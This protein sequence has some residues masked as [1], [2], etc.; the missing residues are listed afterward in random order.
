MLLV[1]VV[2]ATAPTGFAQVPPRPDWRR[3]GNSAVDLS[4]AAVTTGPVARVWYRQ[5]G[6]RLFARS[7]NGRIFYTD[8]F[9]SWTAAPDGVA[10]GPPAVEDTPAPTRPETFV[11]VRGPATRIYAAGRYV[12]KSEDGGRNWANLTRYKERSLIGSGVA[13]LAV[14]PKDDEEIVVAADTGVWRSVDGGLSWSG[15]NQSLPNLP[16]RRLAGFPLDTRGVRIATGDASSVFEW[17]PGEK[18]AWRLAGDDTML[19]EAELRKTLSEKLRARISAV[20]TSGDFVYAGSA[21]G[22]LWASSDGGRT[23]RSNPDRAAAPVEQIA[24]DSKDPRLALAALGDRFADQPATARAPHVLRILNAGAFWDDLTSNL[25]DMAVHGIAADRSTGAVYIATDR[26]LFMAFE[27][28]V[29]AAPAAQWI[30]L[31]DGLPAAAAMDVKLDPAGNQIYAAFEGYGVYAAPAPHRFR[32]PRVVNAA[33]FSTRAAAPGS[34][35]SVLGANVRSAVAGGSPVAILAAAD[36]KSEIQIPFE[37]RGTSIALALESTNGPITV[38]L[39][40]QATAPAIFIDRDSSPVLLDA[41]SGV[42]LDAMNP[43]RSNSRIQIL[44]AG[45]GRVRPE[46][47]TGMAAPVDN[48]PKIVA[49]VRAFLDRQ[50]VEVT[51]AVLAPGYV[52]FYL[53]EIQLPKLVNYGPAELYVEADGQSSNRVRV[54]IEP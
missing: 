36:T 22:Q 47:P 20:A 26:G 33:D 52:G 50:P 7:A 3:I 12:Y 43:A 46:W 1:S 14:S 49:N 19:R 17:A 51:R 44:A 6:N 34:L 4:L 37:A 41:D 39:T 48:P 16:I 38:P 42:M 45:M 11:R 27:D 18:S 30:Q 21:D 10:I 8:D 24:V 29:N 15:L 2:L 5:D 23:F 9:E 31:A 54:Y 32:D 35:L 25:P 53:L 13:D 40:I 28:L